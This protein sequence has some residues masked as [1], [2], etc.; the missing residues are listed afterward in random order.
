MYN[1]DIIMNIISAK[2]CVNKYVTAT[3]TCILIPLSTIDRYWRKIY[4]R[5]FV[6]SILEICSTGSWINILVNEQWYKSGSSFWNGYHSWVTAI[7]NENILRKRYQWYFAVYN[8]TGTSTDVKVDIY[9]QTIE[10]FKIYQ[11]GRQQESFKR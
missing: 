2:E 3:I 9:H 5:C 4:F 10:Y 11:Y 7:R 6:R 1:I 8:D